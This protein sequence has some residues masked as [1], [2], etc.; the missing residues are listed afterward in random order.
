MAQK[1]ESRHQKSQLEAFIEA[2]RNWELYNS[3][4]DEENNSLPMTHFSFWYNAIASNDA[5][6]VHQTLTEI[7]KPKVRTYL[8]NGLFVPDGETDF[9]VTMS[10]IWSQNQQH[11]LVSMEIN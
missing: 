1:H 9:K 6:L 10:N 8:L 2:A 11:Q 5:R 4:T 3:Q 7:A